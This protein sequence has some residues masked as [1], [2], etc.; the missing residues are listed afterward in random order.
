MVQVSCVLVTYNRLDLLKECLQ[1][2]QKQTEALAH[3]VIVNNNSS[4]GTT[5]Y[6]ADLE[7]D[8]YI[9]HNVA[10][11]IGGA[12]GFSLGMKI[13]Y[14][15]TNDDYFWIMDDDTIPDSDC[16]AQLLKGAAN[17]QQHFGF[18]CSNVRWTNGESSNIPAPVVNWSQ[19]ISDNLI[20]VKTATFVSVLVQR[21]TVAE[22]GLPVKEMF[23]WGDDTEYTTRISQKYPSYFVSESIVVHKTKLNLADATLINDEP[24]RIQRYTYLYRNLIYISRRYASK[25]NTVRTYLSDLFYI[26][27]ILAS[28]RDH[29]SLRIR[30]LVSGMIAGLFFNPKVEYPKK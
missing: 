3:I 25:A 27:R 24:N 19:R 30:A 28:A 11:N 4:D 26:F 20:Q 22:L 29:K 2:L 1:A 10:Q 18:L 23:I 6:L 9:V 8:Q 21:K 5:E 7:G 12:A 17:L 13:A 14:Q 16:L 15:Q